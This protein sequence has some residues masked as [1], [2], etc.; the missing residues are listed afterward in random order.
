MALNEPTRKMSKSIP[1]S[2]VSLADDDATIRK[3]VSRA[4]TDAGPAD[5]GMSPGVANLVTL[6]QAFASAD[7]VSHF[8]AQ[9]EAGTLRYSELKPAVGD[10][11]V[12]EL[13]PIRARREELAA[14]PER[15]REALAA[16]A[17]RARGVAQNTMAE[18]KEKMGLK[19]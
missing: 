13:S 6:L 11:I 4:V 3:K 19:Y 16:S 12:T 9:Y 7:T 5:E 8:Q 1:G 17:A 15:V 18:V 10:A 14:H 2:F